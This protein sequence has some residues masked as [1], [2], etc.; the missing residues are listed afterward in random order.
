MCLENV[1]KMSWTKAKSLLGMCV[2]NMS[3]SVSKKS[4]S[5]KSISDDCK[6]NPKCI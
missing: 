4:T 5:H 3:E 6:T 2:S 1:C